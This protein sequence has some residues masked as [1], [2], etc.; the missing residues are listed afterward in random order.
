M[1]GLPSYM[2][3]FADIRLQIISQSSWSSEVIWRFKEL[4]EFQAYNVNNS[5]KII[6]GLAAVA[7]DNCSNI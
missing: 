2:Q 5:S 6:A 1:D 4:N 3:L 7:H